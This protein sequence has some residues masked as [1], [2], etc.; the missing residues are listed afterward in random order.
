M[1]LRY[2]LSI[3]CVCIVSS[4]VFGAIP[5]P[6]L[7][8]GL[9]SLRDGRLEE[10][11]ERFDGIAAAFPSE[12][13][14]PFF[15]AFRLWWRL[16]DKPKNQSSLRLRM[17]ER[18]EEA[19][20]RAQELASSRDE[21][22]A[23][24][25]L[26]FRG[27]SLLLEAQSK[28]ARGAH[29]SAASDA[30]KGHR[31]LSRALD[32][33]PGLPDALFAMGAYDYYADKL[34]LLVK[35][36]RFLLFIPGGNERRGIARLEDAADHSEIFGT[37]SL[38]L[39]A[40]IFSGAFEEDYTRAL[41]YLDRAVARHPDSPM[42]AL[43][44]GEALYQLGRF[45]EAAA[46]ADDALRMASAPGFSPEL[47]RLA[48][49]RRAEC[50]L[51]SHEPL[52]ALDLI[53]AA[54]T[55]SPPIEEDDAVDWMTLLAVAARDAG[56]GERATRWLSRLRIPDEEAISLRRKALSSRDD[57]V[58]AP[59]AA[60][61]AA[62]AAGDAGRARAGIETLIEKHAG[63]PRLQYDIGRLLQEQGLIDQA[64][65]PLETAAATAPPQLAGWALMRLGWALESEGRRTEALEYYRR[66][67]E[68]KRFAFRG[69]A[70]D[71]LMHPDTRQPEG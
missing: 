62:F 32:R 58:A 7:A 19:A 43:A 60:A 28:A 40:H 47:I 14:G 23:L 34:P 49:F 12:P 52:R 53:D 6:T 38:V 63:D 3:I 39:L 20:R 18:L 64:R 50:A 9:E 42:I 11:G 48:R 59:R 54:L 41:G 46:V 21:R 69:A 8:P 37:E 16:V 44:R 13:E 24:H 36:L 55:A 4:L 71:R 5:S 22:T 70:L 33:E 61:L 56:S 66:A 67:S 31:A 68:L 2:F 30:R 45:R 1:R 51:S 10:A 17:E 35:G 26:V 15:Q 65:G 27:A 25:G 57:P 29:L